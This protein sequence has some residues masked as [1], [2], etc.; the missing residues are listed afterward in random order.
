MPELR[1]DPFLDRWVIIAAE[2][3]RRP[4]DFNQTADPLTG[5]FDPFAP[6]NED[7]T[8]PEVAAWGRPAGASPD[9]AGWQVRVVPNK[10][11]A[12]SNV[13]EL[14]PE[15]VG[16]FDK[17]NGVGA[18]EVII[19][20]PR[21]DWDF[22]Q[23]SGDEMRLVLNAYVARY[24][25]LREDRRFR[26]VIVFRN[27]GSAAGAT[28]AH[29]HSQVIAV[30]ILPKHIKEQLAAS[31]DY[32]ERKQRCIYTDVIRQELSQGDRVVEQ[33]E[34][35]VV[36]SPFAARFPFE[37]KIFPRRQCHDFTQSTP[38]EIEA[39]GD[40]LSRTIRRY[41]KALGGPAYN[42]MLQTAP[43]E[44]MHPGHPEY[45]P[46]IDQDFCWHI[47]IL[48]RLTSVAGFEWGTGFYINPVSPEK[49]TQYL[50]EAI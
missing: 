20:H 23:A 26:Y 36:L 47:D 45:W 12:L 24:N 40:T 41:K 50:R 18:H 46:T 38:E 48:P 3:G 8:P 5:A 11:P 43:L 16:M 6:G 37:V 39:L 29:P 2:R 13:G 49:A 28:L 10:F 25:A 9:S 33:N 35:F 17:V 42:M 21:A 15:G 44:R 14:D 19:E 27:V 4:T 22:D 1:K 31:C 32:F 30:P 7:R 34:H